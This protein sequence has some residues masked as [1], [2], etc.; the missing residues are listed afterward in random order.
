MLNLGNGIA[1]PNLKFCSIFLNQDF[2][3]YLLRRM[4]CHGPFIMNER[5][6][7]KPSNSPA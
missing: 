2:T 3:Y 5:L 1:N 6:R 4:V 7:K